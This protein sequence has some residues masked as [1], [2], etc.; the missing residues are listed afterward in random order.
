MRKTASGNMA[1]EKIAGLIFDALSD[2]PSSMN[3]LS[4]KT[5]LHPRTLRRYI[6]FIAM[7]QKKEPIVAER[8]GF[9]IMISKGRMAKQGTVLP[10]SGR[11]A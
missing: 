7:V 6:A 11:L 3:G 5:G 1:K 9:R 10:P 2:G 4:K 8:R